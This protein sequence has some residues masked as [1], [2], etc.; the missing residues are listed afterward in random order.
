MT[1]ETLN[2]PPAWGH[3]NGF[4]DIGAGPMSV[5]AGLLADRALIA[6]VLARYAHSYDERFIE[7]LGSVFTEDA[8]WVGNVAGGFAI[9]PIV[10]GS[11]IVEW[12]QGHMASQSDQRRHNVTNVL[13]TAQT[14][15]TATVMCNLLLTACSDGVTSVVTTGYYVTDFV[16]QDGQWLIKHMFAGFDNAF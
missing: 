16:K 9:D 7:S 4:V 2:P 11:T 6:D 3:T 14:E 10:G 8:E 1:T 13:F 15:S 5:D 12:L